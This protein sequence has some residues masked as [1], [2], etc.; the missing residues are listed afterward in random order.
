MKKPSCG[1]ILT[2]VLG[3][4]LL[5]EIIDTVNGDKQ[6]FLIRWL[7]R[8]D[9]FAKKI[10]IQPYL[11]SDDQVV[12]MLAHPEDALNQ[13]LQRD[14]YLK[15][16]NVVLRIRSRHVV[17]WGTLAWRL[18]DKQI[19]SKVEFSPPPSGT[20]HAR[21]YNDLIIP[22]GVIITTNSNLPPEQIQTKW[23]QL[24]VYR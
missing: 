9:E 5:N 19:W 21:Q 7:F 4:L 3:S 15:N 16:V 10:E 23:V 14:L 1:L 20:K 12:Q 8:E 11:L 17:S 13:P 24:Y 6:I 2:L 22:L 18:N